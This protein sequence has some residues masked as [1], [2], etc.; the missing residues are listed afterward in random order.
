MEAGAEERIELESTAD[1]PSMLARVDASK[2][3]L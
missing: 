2:P 3:V 1:D